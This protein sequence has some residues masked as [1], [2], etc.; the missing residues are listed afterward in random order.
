MLGRTYRNLAV[1]AGVLMLAVSSQVA[2]T[3]AHAPSRRVLGFSADPALFPR[4]SPGI[5][6]YVVRCDDAPVTVSAMPPTHGGCR[7]RGPRRGRATSAST[8]PLRPG[9]P[10]RS[11]SD[12]AGGSSSTR[13]HVRCLP[14]DFPTYT[15]TRSA[16]GLAGF[17]S[18]DITAS[19]GSNATRSSSTATAC[20]SGGTTRPASGPRVLPSGN[21]ALV[22][23]DRAPVVRDPRPRREPGPHA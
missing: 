8:V 4:F 1:V 15:F 13:Y 23:L 2:V 11:R 12:R 5:H 6:D 16:P 9:E 20:R 14:S 18:A 3:S 22:R 17:F 7:S 19:A 10:S 21:I